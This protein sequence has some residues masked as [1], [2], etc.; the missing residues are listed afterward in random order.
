LLATKSGAHLVVGMFEE[1]GKVIA[2]T[3]RASDDAMTGNVADLE[4]IDQ[5]VQQ[6][7]QAIIQTLASGYDTLRTAFEDPQ[8]RT[9]LENFAEEY[10]L[11]ATGL[12]L[13]N[14]DSAVEICCERL[15]V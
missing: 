15:I 14:L 3:A 7:A 10:Y 1:A 4:K 13:L 6:K 8:T 2:L 12:M 5:A 11:N 9:M